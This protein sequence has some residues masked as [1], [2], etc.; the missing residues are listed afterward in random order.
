MF[1]KKRFTSVSV[2]T[3]SKTTFLLKTALYASKTIVLVY[4]DVVLRHL[5]VFDAFLIYLDL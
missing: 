5:N 3:T 1:F 4:S 2:R